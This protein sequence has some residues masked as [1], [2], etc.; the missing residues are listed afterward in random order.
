MGGR[1][2]L[3]YLMVQKAEL[4]L[5]NL[6]SHL[7]VLLIIF[8]ISFYLV[9]LFIYERESEKIFVKLCDRGGVLEK[10]SK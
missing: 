4:D 2:L 3:N 9:F 6:L 7:A 10:S 5:N 8:I 1:F